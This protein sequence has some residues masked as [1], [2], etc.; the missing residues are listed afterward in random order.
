MTT[1]AEGNRTTETL[2]LAVEDLSEGVAAGVLRAVQR[3]VDI[4]A[5][6]AKGRTPT[7]RFTILIGGDFGWFDLRANRLEA[8]VAVGEATQAGPV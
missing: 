6:L 4:E 5:Q 3:G 7:A 1:A 8:G 2:R